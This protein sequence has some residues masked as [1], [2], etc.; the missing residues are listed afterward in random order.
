MMNQAKQVVAVVITAVATSAVGCT[1]TFHNMEG[2]PAAMRIEDNPPKVLLGNYEYSKVSVE[3][4]LIFAATKLKVSNGSF[5]C[6][7][8]A[9]YNENTQKTIKLPF[10]CTDGRTGNIIITFSKTAW[11]ADQRA[12][13]VGSLNDG[14]KLKLLLGNMDGAFAW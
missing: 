9:D 13:G 12:I 1:T 8:F 14:T 3:G 7:G 6:V 10:E 4:G 2:P 11:R 5:D